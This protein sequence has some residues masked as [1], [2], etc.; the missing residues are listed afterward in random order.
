MIRLLGVIAA[1][2][3]LLCADLLIAESPPWTKELPFQQAAITYEISGMEV[4]SEV[5]YLKNYGRISA[6]HRQTSMMMFG[7]IQTRSSVEITTPEW[8]YLF[9]LQERKGSKS[10]NPEKLMI[11][12]FQKLSQEDRQKV[13]DNAEK[14]A[15]VLGGGLQGIV[16]QNAVEILGYWCDKT[17]AL[18]STIYTIHDTS[19]PLLSETDIMGIKIKSVATSID[20]DGV[21]DRYFDFPQD[22][23]VHHDEEADQMAQMVAQ[24]T[25]AA[26]KDPESYKSRTQGLIGTPSSGSPAISP[27][28]Q[29]EMEEAMQKIKELLGN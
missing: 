20:T 7:L 13:S 24:Q 1:A 12:K 25:M 4:G 29:K 17:S 10:I 21:D 11:E 9:D 8:I 15:N 5:L 16:E 2:A 22:I 28:D 26:L 6:R 3:V 18:G 23:P 27:E 14:M 19:L